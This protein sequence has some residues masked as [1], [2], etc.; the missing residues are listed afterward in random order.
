MGIFPIPLLKRDVKLSAAA[1]I[2]VVAT[3]VFFEGLWALW[4]MLIGFTQFHF[5]FQFAI[6][7]LIGGPLLLVGSKIGYWYS[8]I[9]MTAN[10]IICTASLTFMLW[11]DLFQFT[12]SD[13]N[14]GPIILGWTAFTAAATFLTIWSVRMLRSAEVRSKFD[15]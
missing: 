1:A 12:S 9:D 4:S 11:V 15:L 6:L 8:L 10:A 3:L 7:G 13:P 14:R 2:A 5:G